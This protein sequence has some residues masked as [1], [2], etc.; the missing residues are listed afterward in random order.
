[1]KIQSYKIQEIAECMQPT[2]L[3]ILNKGYLAITISTY[4]N[5]FSPKVYQQK[6]FLLF[7]RILI[8][9]SF[10]IRIRKLNFGVNH[11][12]KYPDYIC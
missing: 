1:M 3:L 9:R 7:A 5:R 10:K 6:L 2:R 12:N 11:F 4:V 8:F